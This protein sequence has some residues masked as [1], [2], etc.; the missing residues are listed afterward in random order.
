MDS[1][2]LE[3]TSVHP[4]AVRVMNEIN[5]DLDGQRSVETRKADVRGFGP[6]YCGM[7]SRGRSLTRQQ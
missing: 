4:L 1:A 2:G 5:L 7:C 6:S 3:P